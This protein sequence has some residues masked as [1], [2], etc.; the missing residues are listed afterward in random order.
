M[1]R[2]SMNE[3]W[4]DQPLDEPEEIEDEDEDTDLEHDD[5]KD[6]DL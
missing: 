3:S 5:L 2:Y 4:P 1:R 6:R